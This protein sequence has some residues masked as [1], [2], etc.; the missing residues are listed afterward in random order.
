[1]AANFPRLVRDPSG[2]A[3][4]LECSHPVVAVGSACTWR[5]QRSVSALA[6]ASNSHRT[7]C[8]PAGP[9]PADYPRSI[10]LPAPRQGQ[11]VLQSSHSVLALG[12]RGERERTST[13]RHRHRHRH[14]LMKGHPGSS[15]NIF[16]LSLGPR[17]RTP[18]RP[19]TFLINRRGVR[20]SGRGSRGGWDCG[21]WVG[22]G[23][24]EG[25]GLY[26]WPTIVV[27]NSRHQ[28][29]AACDPAASCPFIESARVHGRAR[30]DV[31]FSRLG[32]R[33]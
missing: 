10:S 4:C 30:R 23:R 11:A 25:G 13:L 33:E 3:E 5:F 19:L 18:F 2:A 22:T 16:V 27:G 20:R 17:R 21:D 12:R 32:L 6:R 7:A 8:N 28:H 1:M 14:L 24:G 15:V 26:K 31:Y 29:P 9:V